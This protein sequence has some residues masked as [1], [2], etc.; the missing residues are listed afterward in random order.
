MFQ[1]FSEKYLKIYVN[2]RVND[3][4]KSFSNYMRIFDSMAMLSTK[5]LFHLIS[6]YL[7]FRTYFRSSNDFILSSSL[8]CILTAEPLHISNSF[9]KN[10]E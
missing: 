10:F 9:I 4:P 3:A 5:I 6:N 7:K 2:E 1:I 8:N